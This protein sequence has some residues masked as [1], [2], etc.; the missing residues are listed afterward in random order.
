MNTKKCVNDL[1]ISNK[2]RK[3]KS[4]EKNYEKTD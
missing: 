4:R 2:K 1:K 3:L